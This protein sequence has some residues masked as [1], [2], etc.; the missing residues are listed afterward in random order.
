MSDRE[1]KDSYGS[2][3]IYIYIYI[4]YIYIYT[5]LY[6][7]YIYIYIKLRPGGGMSFFQLYLITQQT[8]Y[9]HVYIYICIRTQYD[10]VLFVG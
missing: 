5:Y 8:R 7:E 4:K 3:C 1:A 9:P 10:I 2:E 6:I